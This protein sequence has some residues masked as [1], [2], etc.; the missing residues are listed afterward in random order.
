[1]PSQPHKG[2]HASKGPKLHTPTLFRP[3]GLFETSCLFRSFTTIYSHITSRFRRISSFVA[4]MVCGNAQFAAPHCH[5]RLLS[6]TTGSNRRLPLLGLKTSS[7]RCIPTALFRVPPLLTQAQHCQQYP[8]LLIQ[9]VRRI[10][11]M[12]SYSG[13]SLQGRLQQKSYV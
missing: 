6:S 11:T 12:G 8:P 3:S 10:K 13:R 1:M 4:K 7:S 9:S 5:Y 2:R